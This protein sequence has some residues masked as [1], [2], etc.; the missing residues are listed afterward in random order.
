MS[1]ISSSERASADERVRRIRDE[2][3]TKEANSEKRREDELERV[4]DQH[5]KELDEVKDVFNRQIDD[6]R[7]KGKERLNAKDVE[8]RQEIEEIRQFY[9]DSMRKKSEESNTDKDQI[10]N[11]YEG[12]LKKDK[13]IAEA[14]RQNLLGQLNNEI[15]KRDRRYVQD[16][17]ENRAEARELIAKNNLKNQVSHDRELNSIVE[18]HQNEISRRDLDAQRLK[19]AHDIELR[20]EGLRNESKV[21]AANSKY[22][23]AVRNFQEL[24]QQNLESQNRLLNEAR[25]D[26]R[27]KY[28]NA[29]RKKQDQIDTTLEE[30]KKEVD[31]R[32]DNQVHAREYEIARLKN[33]NSNDKR[34]NERLKDLEIK[35]LRRDFQNRV[36]DLESQKNEL[37]ENMV[38]TNKERIDRLN[39]EHHDRTAKTIRDYKEEL[40][41]INA[42]NKEDRIAKEQIQKET[43]DHAITQ[44]DQRVKAINQIS[45]KSISKARDQYDFALENAKDNF[46]DRL[47]TQREDHFVERA[48][49][50]AEMRERVRVMQGQHDRKIKEL[51]NG[52]QEQTEALK[53][54]QMR[55]MDGLH[56]FY[57][58]RIEEL[59]RGHKTEIAS[60]EA[61][62]ENKIAQMNETHQAEIDRMRERHKEDFK[63]FSQR[64]NRKA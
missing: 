4:N 15:E 32:V 61:K 20:S 18:G 56:E 37:K 46:M 35:A 7:E 14:Q 39:Q 26:I 44:A 45:N 59:N 33:Q 1:S 31:S 9:R 12:M 8:N 42:R 30:I 55:Q 60:T 64:Q 41:F 19:R 11:S 48:N 24:N 13:Q 38:E 5:R 23:S 51:A 62:Y 52:Y 10:R 36:Q 58:K 49:N 53:E 28:D 16:L 57:K 27:D 6:M 63:N 50:L 40:S 2:Y 17:N 21:N 3:E 43:I 25:L 34:S 22:D 54:E 47:A 29:L